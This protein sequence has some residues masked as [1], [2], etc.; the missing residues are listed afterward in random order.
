MEPRMK[1]S[2]I[3]L[4]DAF[5][6]VAGQRNRAGVLVD[7]QGLSETS[8]QNIARAVAVSE[9]AVVLPGT[10]GSRL[11][12]RYFTP[13]TEVPFCGHATVATLHRLAENRYIGAGRYTFDCLAGRLDFEIEEFDGQFRVW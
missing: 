5:T 12:L 2:P 1:T 8:M 3:A 4:V 7:A 10:A 11:R 6:R 9:T 13:T